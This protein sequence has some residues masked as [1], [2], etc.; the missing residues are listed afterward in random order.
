MLVSTTLTLPYLNHKQTPWSQLRGVKQDF[1]G[2][3]KTNL[4]PVAQ[5]VTIYIKQ[6]VA[7]NCYTAVKVLLERGNVM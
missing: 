1:L 2:C 3:C 7:R 4:Y 5:C 6:C